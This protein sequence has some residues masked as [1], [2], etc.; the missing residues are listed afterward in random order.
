MDKE[1]RLL[2]RTAR[3][4]NDPDDIERLQIARDRLGPTAHDATYLCH[5]L[6]LCER[7]ISGSITLYQADAGARDYLEDLEEDEF[8]DDPTANGGIGSP[9]MPLAGPGF[10]Q[11]LNDE[12]KFLIGK[13]SLRNSILGDRLTNSDYDGFML[14]RVC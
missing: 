4:T 13:A 6:E 8:V 7:Y 10:L 5:Y 12:F 11:V 3:A 14:S 9:E 1:I 2:E